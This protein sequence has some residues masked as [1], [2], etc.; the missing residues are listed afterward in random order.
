MV[1]TKKKH[2]LLSSW[3]AG[4]K[5]DLVIVGLS[6]FGLLLQSSTPGQD[7]MERYLSSNF[8]ADS[9]Y[10]LD[11]LLFFFFSMTV[12]SKK[13]LT[14]VPC[15]PTSPSGTSPISSSQTFFSWSD[16]LGDYNY[17]SGVMS[18]TTDIQLSTGN[19]TRYNI[20]MYIVIPRQA[21][22][23]YPNSSVR[24]DTKDDSSWDRNPADL[25]PVGYLTVQTSA[26]SA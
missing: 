5:N 25:T 12:F 20:Y 13:F 6:I 11:F 19:F 4:E 23:L 24:L 3:G 21:V 18:L 14:L 2:Q 26:T 15:G 8:W 1:Y 10:E 16:Q 7:I 22:N 9:K 17:T